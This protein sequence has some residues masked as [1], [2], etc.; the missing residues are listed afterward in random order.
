MRKSEY[1]KQKIRSSHNVQ[2]FVIGY[3][4]SAIK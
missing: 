4:T 3:E 2:S 1:E